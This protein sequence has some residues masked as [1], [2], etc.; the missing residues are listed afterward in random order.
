MEVYK[1]AEKR[2]G[3]IASP[4]VGGG[5]MALVDNRENTET[6]AKLIKGIKAVTPTIQRSGD[7]SASVAL[8]LPDLG[9]AFPADALFIDTVKLTGRTNTGFTKISAKT[10]RRERTQGDHTIA[11]T[12]IKTYQ[13]GMLRDKN[14]LDAL[15]FYDRNFNEITNSENGLPPVSPDLTSESEQTERHGVVEQKVTE[16]GNLIKE[17]SAQVLPMPLWRKGLVRVINC[18]NEAYSHS[19]AAT[20]YNS[21]KPTGK[22]EASKKKTLKKLFLSCEPGALPSDTPSLIDHGALVRAG[23]PPEY[24]VGR[25]EGMVNEMHPDYKSHRALFKGLEGTVFKPEPEPVS[26]LD[27]PEPPEMREARR[28]RD[29]VSS[30]GDKVASYARLLILADYMGIGDKSVDMFQ[31]NLGWA[32]N[33]PNYIAPLVSHEEVLEETSEETPEEEGPFDILKAIKAIQLEGVNWMIVL[34]TL[35]LVD[36]NDDLKHFVNLALEFLLIPISGRDVATEVMAGYEQIDDM[37]EKLLQRLA[38]VEQQLLGPSDARIPAQ[39]A[40]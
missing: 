22:G 3:E 25:Y 31:R 2:T 17:L 30:I 18:Y 23:Y 14:I 20:V 5:K 13:K 36:G 26:E 39:E 24:F 38:S 28:M 33:D 6:Q 40:P 4:N 27:I 8:R 37:K 9:A 16:G 21:S 12:F 29:L 11:D 32:A 10:H 19:K 34:N 15:G 1:H 7:F 35:N